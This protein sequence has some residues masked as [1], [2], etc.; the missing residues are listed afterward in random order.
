MIPYPM[1]SAFGGVGSEEYYVPID[2]KIFIPTLIS[3]EVEGTLIETVA[4]LSLRSCSDLCSMIGRNC[5]D[6]AR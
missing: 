4:N 5:R 1:D 3:F 2:N 6:P